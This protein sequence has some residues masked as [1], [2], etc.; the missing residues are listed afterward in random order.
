MGRIET[1]SHLDVIPEPTLQ[2]IHSTMGEFT[3]NA[4]N[5]SLNCTGSYSMAEHYIPKSTKSSET[6]IENNRDSRTT[7]NVSILGDSMTVSLEGLYKKLEEM[8]QSNS[9]RFE[10]MIGNKTDIDR[11]FKTYD[12]AFQEMRR[13]IEGFENKTFSKGVQK[14]TKY[15]SDSTNKSSLENQI[16]DMAESLK[17]LYHKLERM[18]QTNATQSKIEKLEIELQGMR[19]RLESFENKKHLGYYN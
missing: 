11:R 3:N 1:P 12:I 7:S 6:M 8:E 4:I 14:I 18:E 15:N 16:D 2:I 19:R 17:G 13:S 10:K 5:Q 9:T